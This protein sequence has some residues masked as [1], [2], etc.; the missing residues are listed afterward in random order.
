MSITV[1]QPAY[2]QYRHASLSDAERFMTD[3]GF[4]PCGR[5]DGSLYFRGVSSQGYCYVAH[6][7]EPAFVAGGFEVA[8]R[9]V[10]E[11]ASR[12]IETASAVLP[13]PGPQGGLHVQLRDPDGFRIDL[14]AEREP[15]DPLPET[16]STILNFGERKQ[17]FGTFQRFERRPA[18]IRRLGHFGFNVSSF[19]RTFTWYRENLG[20]LS[21]DTLHAGPENTN[22]AAFMRVAQGENWVD[23][24][25]VF[26]LESPTTH[27]HHCSFEVQ[28]PDEVMMGSEW[29]KSKGWKQVWGVGRH[30]LGSQVFDYW[31]DCSGF[32]IEHYADGD[33]L[34][35]AHEGERHHVAEEALSVWGPQAPA[36]Y[37]D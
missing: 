23:H 31:R 10:L 12:T 18:Q 4:V 32:M 14:V 20:M 26:F 29:L 33:I 8:S 19:V 5:E 6:E 13:L 2:V 16:K 9:D 21:S 1:L 27:V 22:V 36:D 7:G 24:H 28:D 35:S 3:F 30:I 37:L 17:R 15:L 11:R 25:S 34:T